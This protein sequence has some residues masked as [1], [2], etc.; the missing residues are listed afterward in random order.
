MILLS[1][2]KIPRAVRRAKALLLVCLWLMPAGAQPLKGIVWQPPSDLRRAE[3][4]L[5][6]MHSMGVE[7]V[8]TGLVAEPG[9][10]DLADSLELQLFQELPVEHLSASAL[11][12]AVAASQRLLEQSLAIS[13][14]HPSA[15]HYGLS[16]RSDTS[17]ASACT[18]F[19]LLSPQ[20]RSI[21]GAHVY[22]VSA[23]P[24]SDRCRDT[25]DFVLF[26][27]REG[28]PPI[29][30]AAGLATLGLWTRD[31]AWR[32]LRNPHSPESQA[33]F[34]EDHLN[35]LLADTTGLV[36]VFVHQWRDVV[37]DEQRAGPERPDP[38]GRLYGLYDSA[39]NPRPALQVVAGIY[40][41]AQTVFAFP[42][43]VPA[44]S[45]WPW[46]IVLGWVAIGLIGIHFARSPGFRFMVP[47]YFFAHVFYRDAV[48]EG[49]DVL[50]DA[51][52]LLL[53]V[54][55]ICVSIV[56]G[57]LANSFRETNAVIHFIQSLG[58][59][60]R[61]A[62]VGVLRSP[63]ML[64]VQVGSVYVLGLGLWAMLLTIASR[65]RGRLTMGQAIMLVV[66]PR[67]PLLLL[68]V[69]AMTLSRGTP[70]TSASSAVILLAAWLVASL[71]SIIRTLVDFASVT[72]S[73]W[74][75]TIIV[76]LTD[77]FIILCLITVIPA[78]TIF[79]EQTAFFWHLL[80]RG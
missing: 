43:G 6:E 4:D 24:E 31:D 32:G 22:Y 70:G 71:A 79:S 49:R 77:P 76:G 16:R 57:V 64:V 2:V 37:P 52:A 21:P 14:N 28:L 1:F 61:E 45:S 50:P 65:G 30:G 18:F 56:G 23:F 7:A 35:A 62:V 8:R 12:G 17:D 78:M 27:A 40:S 42:A 72:G 53:V 33:R 9:L 46:G 68:M 66:W 48:R 26:D 60:A 47:R 51:S 54:L 67:W 10:L 75:R 3:A 73:S 80:L 25:V 20:V 59:T 69:I 15:R 13:R 44:S 38:F 39:S 19:S 63:F 5:R 74:R 41:G 36:A 29:S 58:P 11:I 34:L 55:G